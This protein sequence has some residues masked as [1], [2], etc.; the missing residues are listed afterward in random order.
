MVSILASWWREET[1]RSGSGTMRNLMYSNTGN[2]KYGS[3][4]KLQMLQAQSCEALE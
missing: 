2:E 3:A 1:G 4:R